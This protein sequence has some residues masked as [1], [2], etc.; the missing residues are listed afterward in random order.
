MSNI[1]NTNQRDLFLGRKRNQAEDNLPENEVINYR[2]DSR[3]EEGELPG[4]TAGIDSRRMEGNRDRSQDRYFKNYDR[5][6]RNDFRN[7]RDSGRDR[8]YQ[9]KFDNNYIKYDRNPQNEYKRRNGIIS[10]G[11]DDPI[12]RHRRNERQEFDPKYKRNN[13]FKTREDRR[14][15]R[16]YA[17]PSY[18]DEF[19]HRERE[20]YN[21]NSTR[22]E[23]K[24]D[25][26]RRYDRDPR[27]QR[28]HHKNYRDHRDSNKI[29]EE[30]NRERNFFDHKLPS[31]REERDQDIDRPD[32]SDRDPSKRGHEKV[33]EKEKAFYKEH[34]IEAGDEDSESVSSE[35]DHGGKDRNKS[36]FPI[37][38]KKFNFLMI[39]PKNYFRFIEKEYDYLYSEVI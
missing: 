23:D 29:K 4:L 18:I 7:E 10:L 5:P 1:T 15:P 39:L 34:P 38:K 14:P 26:V 19:S 20:N 8:G 32:R 17:Q 28:D 30:I 12:Q 6:Q 11:E 21:S 9:R 31:R 16:E 22:R 25:N 27:D 13:D 37:M 2:E 35:Y 3:K 36:G 33:E 24:K